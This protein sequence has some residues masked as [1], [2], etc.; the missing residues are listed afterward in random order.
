MPFS[1]HRISGE[2]IGSMFLNGS[3]HYIEMAQV[4]TTFDWSVVL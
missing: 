2:V 4:E 3:S 1:E